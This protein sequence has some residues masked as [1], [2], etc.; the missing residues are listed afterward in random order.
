MAENVADISRATK[1]GYGDPP[2]EHEAG[3]DEAPRPVSSW[4]NRNPVS[5]DRVA[6]V[7][8]GHVRQLLDE[9]VE[10]ERAEQQQRRTHRTNGSG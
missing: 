4:K 3:R 10:H 6:G 7:P 1:N 9:D 8:G 2:T 5:C